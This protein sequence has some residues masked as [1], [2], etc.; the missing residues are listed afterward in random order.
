MQEIIKCGC[1]DWNRYIDKLPK[2]LRD[3]YFREAYYKLQ[4]VNGAGEG[5][6]FVYKEE[7]NI[8]IYPFVLNEIK[9]Y[10]LDEQY[11]DIETAYGYGGPLINCIDSGFNKR[12][13][14]SFIDYCKSTNIIA[15]FIRFHPLLKN[16]MIF[17]EN[18]NVIN[19]RN[20]VYID[21][22]KSIDDIWGNDIIS[23]NR[24]V[25]RKAKKFGLTVNF[26]NDMNT[27][28]EIYMKTMDKVSAQG[29]YY[30]N[31]A[32]YKALNNVNNVCINVKFENKTV[33]S[34]IFMM[35]DE[36]FHY[37]LS[38]SLREY[39]KYAPNN[40]MLWSA[41]QYAKDNGFSKFHL[42]GGLSNS[43]QDNLYKFKKSF[44]KDV[45]DFYIGTRIHNSRIYDYL[46]NI[47]E[48]KNTKKASLFL[49]YKI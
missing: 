33:A 7:E 11:Y 8:A 46:I 42:G 38:G 20:T 24:N 34:G 4:E 45:T 41:I 1:N 19:N 31:E 15:E 49:Q 22:N 3:V 29:Y 28:K 16:E 40:L 18:I 39:L 13:E 5:Q 17:K 6:L 23:K 43:V 48:I 32:Y 9:G 37:H 21:L 44:G 2:K 36:I 12:F 10:E 14:S 27:F 30:F 26:D 25:I 47:W 35:G